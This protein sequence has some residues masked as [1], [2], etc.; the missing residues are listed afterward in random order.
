MKSRLFF[1]LFFSG[2]LIFETPLFAQD[3]TAPKIQWAGMAA[4]EEGQF[5][6]CQYVGDPGPM[7]F[8]PWVADEY[9]EVGVKATLNQHFS[10]VVLPEI[11]LW[12]DTWD[13]TR[14]NSSTGPLNPLNQHATVWLADAE[15]IASFGSR[16]AVAWN[17]SAGVIPYK[18]DLEAKNLGEY[19]FRTGEHPTYIETAFDQAYATLTGLRANAEIFHNLSLDLFFTTETQVQP[20]NDWSLSLLAGYKVPGLLDFGAG[21]MFDRL[22][23]AVPFLDKPSTSRYNTYYTSSGELDTFSWGGTKVMARLSID[24]KGLL[25]TDISQIFGKEDGILYGESAILGVTSITPY[26]PELGSNG[27]PVAGKYVID[28]GNT[29]DNAYSDIWKRIPVIFGFNFPTFK[30][31]DYLSVELEW[32]GGTYSPSLYDLEGF[33]YLLPLPD[34]TQYI[35]SQWK[36]SFN[37]RKTLMSNVSLI[38]Q[39]AR[40][41]TRHDV[42]FF[43]NTDVD[44]IFQTKDEWGWWLKLQ[45]NI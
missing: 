28:T 29:I 15:G 27:L 33:K 14:M 35:G 18:Y 22:I 9:A 39:I 38:G 44:E 24:P 23:P 42:Y 13:W 1:V 41:H 7:P 10:M 6:K 16:D 12:D 32:F 19:L 21:I 45:C 26:T 5:V 8:S 11:E 36:Y 4:I 3:S 37:V 17:F 30:L 31:L 25:S 20:M 43:G 40:D 34:G 2:C